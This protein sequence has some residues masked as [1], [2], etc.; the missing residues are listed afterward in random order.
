[1]Y[2]DDT[3]ITVVGKTGEEIE[4]SLNSEL[5]NVYNSLLANKL[6]FNVNETEYMIIGSRQKLQN[7]NI[8]SNIK[9]ACGGN[10]VKQVLTTKSLGIIIDKNLCWKEHIDNISKRV[11]RAIGMISRAKPYVNTGCLKLMYQSLVLPYL[12]YCSLVWANCNQTLKN[13]VQR[14]QNRAA[15][16]I[17]GDSYDIRSKDILSKLGWKNLEERRIS[18]TEACVTKALQGKC[19]EN[20]NAMF[21]PSN[22]E[23]YRLRDNNLVLMLSKPNTNAMK[24]SFSYAAAKIWNSQDTKIR[25]EILGQ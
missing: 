22:R 10:E 1:M 8:N 23:N 25:K 16:V 13:E 12:D 14:L 15:R 3:N 11:S 19:P 7:T 24:R 4:K 2:A 9:I 17:T 18:Q 20:I 6:T 5:E 21:M